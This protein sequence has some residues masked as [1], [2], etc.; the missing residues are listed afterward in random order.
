MA[1]IRKTLVTSTVAAELL[2]EDAT[3]NLPELCQICGIHAE[4]I[5]EL[6]EQGALEPDGQDPANW[7]FDI[8]AVK[9]AYRGIR[10]S[11]DF[12]LE[13]PAIAIILDLLD[14]IDRLEEKINQLR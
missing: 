8:N 11:R 12:N 2:D 13:A 9:R 14:E 10:L 5:I 1:Q 4:F 6:I 7:I 3:F